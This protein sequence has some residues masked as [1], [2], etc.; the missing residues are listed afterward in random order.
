MKNFADDDSDRN[1]ESPTIS[2]QTSEAKAPGASD[3]ERR[4]TNASGDRA[5]G[6]GSHAPDAGDPT[7]ATRDR[8]EETG[9]E[10]IEITEAMIEAA[11]GIAVAIDDVTPNR[12][13]AYAQ[14]FSAMILAASRSNLKVVRVT[15]KGET[16]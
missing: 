3:A 5:D 9:K 13:R 10:E 11:D 7:E 16:I 1:F 14:I 12:H 8:G 4:E 15:F 2:A 6:S